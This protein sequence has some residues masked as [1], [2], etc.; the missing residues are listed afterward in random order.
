MADKDKTK[1]PQTKHIPKDGQVIMAIMKEMGIT[2][3]EPKTIVQLT[4]FVY[5]YATSILEEARMYTN[6]SKQKF[7]GVDD[8]RLALQLT[9]E[10]TFTTPP[11][12]EVLMELA[13]V[14]NYSVLPQ[15]KPHCGLRLPPDRYCLSSCNYTLRSMKKSSRPNFGMPGTPTL[16]ITPKT[17]IQFLKRSTP[18]IAKQTVTI[19]KAVTKVITNQPQKTI[20]KPKIEITQNLQLTPSNNSNEMDFEI[21]GSLKRKREDEHEPMQM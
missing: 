8:V 2:D 11:P 16:K 18:T 7:L 14:K 9:C 13:H 6:N 17:N 21:L 15:V 19:P 4:E 3:Y 5:R 1:T 20:L 10:S 12:R